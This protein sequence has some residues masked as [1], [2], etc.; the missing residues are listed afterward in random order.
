MAGVG[1]GSRP[2]G[3]APRTGF[4]RQIGRRSLQARLGVAKSIESC[5]EDRRGRSAADGDGDGDDD[6][7]PGGAV[8]AGQMMMMMLCWLLAASCS[9]RPVAPWCVSVP[10]HCTRERETSPP[11][12]TP[13]HGADITA[14]SRLSTTLPSPRVSR[15]VKRAHQLYPPRPVPRVRVPP[16]APSPRSVLRPSI[17]STSGRQSSTRPDTTRSYLLLTV[18]CPSTAACS[19][20]TSAAAAAAVLIQTFPRP[21][22]QGVSADSSSSARRRRCAPSRSSLTGARRR[23]CAKAQA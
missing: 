12:A 7:A 5:A 20:T 14:T 16:E 19:T 11:P 9:S 1:I 18:R 15:S 3:E 8:Q 23:P 17:R 22:R 10:G 4:A 6:A 21:R 13:R 2:N